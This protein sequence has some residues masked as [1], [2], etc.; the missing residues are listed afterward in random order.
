MMEETAVKSMTSHRDEFLSNVARTQF[1]S[2]VQ[3]MHNRK[4]HSKMHSAISARQP[5]AENH[6]IT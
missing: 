2:T 1:S 5:R 4:G 6:V 3:E